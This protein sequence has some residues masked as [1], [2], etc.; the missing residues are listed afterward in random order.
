MKKKTDKTILARIV[1]QAGYPRSSKKTATVLSK[2]RKSP[3][4]TERTTGT[5][6]IIIIS[7]ING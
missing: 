6:S 2:H 7:S 3:A 1:K 5:I 4:T